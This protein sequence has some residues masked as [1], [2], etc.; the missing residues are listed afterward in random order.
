MLA[1]QPPYYQAAYQYHM[2]RGKRVLA[3]A[4]KRAPRSGSGS[5]SKTGPTRAEVETGL[6]FLGFLLY[7]CDLKADTKSVIRE[8]RLSNHRVMMITGDS[9]Y[10]AADVGRRVNL[11]KSEGG[12]RVLRVTA[13]GE[14]VWRDAARGEG[15]RREDGDID[16]T[17]GEIAQ[18]ASS[19]DLCVIGSSLTCVVENS[20]KADAASGGGSRVARNRAL[21]QLCPHVNIFAR[22]SPAQKE[23]VITALNDSGL[24]TLM[25]G[26]GTNDVGA[27]KA[28]HVGVSIVNDPEFESSIENTVGEGSAATAGTASEKGQKKA[29]GTCSVILLFF[30]LFLFVVLFVS[31]LIYYCLPVFSDTT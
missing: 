25:C 6:G 7:D 28:A 16:F 19:H 3:L 20:D 2:N 14:L 17:P 9:P 21:Q 27:L 30:H 10:T 11:T 12:V 31:L 1:V 22:V 5:N 29:K 15:K 18:L 23:Q 4:C 8:L 26:D 13:A 24:H